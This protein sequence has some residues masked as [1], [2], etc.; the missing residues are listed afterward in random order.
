[1]K[2]QKTI[3]SIMTYIFLGT[4][5]LQI[6]V[7]L[8]IV[9]IGQVPKV[10]MKES[11]SHF[12][13]H[14]EENGNLIEEFIRAKSDLGYYG[15]DLKNKIENLYNSG[16]EI[17][18]YNETDILGL[19][20][21]LKNNVVG[22]LNNSK[23]ESAFVII[24]DNVING[25]LMPRNGIYLTRNSNY[26][27]GEKLYNVLVKDENIIINDS[28]V[29]EDEAI[30]KFEFSSLND[31]DRYYNIL[32]ELAISMDEL[33][34]YTFDI[35]NQKLINKFV[36]TIS[37][38]L[39]NSKNELIAVYG[40][41]ISLDEFFLSVST[42]P[43]I[44][45]S[46]GIRNPSKDEVNSYIVWD[47][48]GSRT[49]RLVYQLTKEPV[50]DKYYGLVN[51]ENSTVN[52]IPLGL[53]DHSEDGG[54][55]SYYYNGTE[56]WVLF[57]LINTDRLMSNYKFVENIILVIISLSLLFGIAMIWLVIHRIAKPIRDLSLQVEN[58]PRGEY[59]AFE[60]T[61]VEEVN[62]LIISFEKLTYDVLQYSTRL[63]SAMTSSLLGIYFYQ[64]KGNEVYCSQTFLTMV[65]SELREGNCPWQ[66]FSSIYEKIKSSQYNS[67]YQA[68]RLHTGIWLKL[69]EKVESGFTLGIASDVSDQVKDIQK[70]EKELEID[71]FTKLYNKIAFDKFATNLLKESKNR[72]A[73]VIMW[74]M[75]KLK[76]VN[77][78]FGHDAGDNY[79]L[80]FSKLIKELESSTSV[81]A[82]R[83]GDEFLAILSGKTRQSIQK[84][85]EDFD[86]K[87]NNTYLKVNKEISEQLRVSKGVAWFPEEADNLTSLLNI[88]EKNLYKAK[89]EYKGLVSLF[90]NPEAKNYNIFHF[91]QELKKI[92]SGNYITFLYQPIV[93]AKTGDIYGYEL[94]MRIFNDVI[95]SPKKLIDIAIENNKLDQV[96]AI[97]FEEGFSCYNQN[98]DLLVNKKVFINSLA[99][100]KLSGTTLRRIIKNNL[101]RLQNVVVEL[102]NVFSVDTEVLKNRIALFTNQNAKIAIDNFKFEYI[103]KLDPSL[104]IEYIK[105]DISIVQDLHYSTGQQKYLKDIISFAKKKK[106]KTIAVGIRTQKE[107]E[108]V[109][110]AG[111]DYVQGFYLGN[112]LVKPSSIDPKVVNIIKKMN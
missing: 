84:Q 58:R 25:D 26:K 69:E 95:D 41:D 23:A 105:V 98:Q 11:Y 59:F 79:I 97:T 4:I 20:D 13:Y 9:Y 102:S 55:L 62:N 81:V 91:N 77:D 101:I 73:A 37:F 103:E 106:I 15:E 46:I 24:E 29:N 89:F 100:A 71:E 3:T 74:D 112:P 64:A 50:M 99:N 17:A 53:K 47:G 44:T 14:L 12:D 110:A 70:F 6:F 72:V 49:D 57:A 36:I 1:M 10:I 43:D 66:E 90:E 31:D 51:R 85:I 63:S 82:R 88:A 18:D 33:P 68:F 75:D 35:V 42:Y 65:G 5:V 7:L 61:E 32:K 78:R 39:K 107:L 40:V 109:I 45:Y 30:N 111:V 22:I 108:F 76:Y 54:S 21:D 104:D 2:K 67:Q 48:E 80:E 60:K 16:E 93:S 96:E 34:E 28:N 27:E 87:V 83:S 86:R 38:P 94:L 56:Y 92:L 19:I 52:F 8:S